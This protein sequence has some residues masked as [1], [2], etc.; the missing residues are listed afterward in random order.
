MLRKTLFW[1]IL[2]AFLVIVLGSL[3]ALGWFSSHELRS[4]FMDRMK[5][6]LEK[7]AKLV[8]HSIKS[9]YPDPQPSEID[10]I[11]KRIGQLT[12]SR[13]TVIAPDGSVLGDSDENPEDMENHAD[14][15]EIRAAMQGHPAASERYSTTLQQNMI[16]F[17]VP[18]RSADSLLGV[19]RTSRSLKSFE[20]AL[21]ATR[22]KIFLASCVVGLFAVL[23][24][25][26][27]SQRV[28]RPLS[29]IRQGA[30]RFAN[31]NLKTRLP[32]FDVAEFQLLANTMNHMAAELD[33][34]IGTVIQQR[35]E[36]E[37]ILSSMTEGVLAVDTEAKIIRLNRAAAEML[38]LDREQAQGKTVQATIRNAGLQKA[39][40]QTLS[41]EQRVR[42][43][44]VAY[45][46]EERYF[47]V[48]GALV[49][50][51]ADRVMGAVLVLNDITQMRKLENIRKDF[52]A[53][54]SH[55]LRTPITSI[56][57]FVETLLD[58]ALESKP[59]AERFLGIILKQT[60]RLNAILEDLLLLSR[61]ER[62]DEEPGLE[63]DRHRLK[64]VLLTA[65][66]VCEHK[67]KDKSI[68]ITLNCPADIYACLNPLLMEQAAVNIIDN[69][70]NYSPEGSAIEV[71]AGSEN[72]EL[73][74]SVTDQGCGIPPE[75]LPRIFERFYR[76]DKARSRQ[77][78]GTGLG[79]AILK[80]VAQAHGGRVSVDS[81]VGRGSTFR[82]HLP[83]TAES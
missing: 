33:D 5:T 1:K 53:N 32:Y 70:I 66:Q 3:L 24:S 54:V 4:F 16:Y 50:D 75:H 11:C 59:D 30:Q 21:S 78:G 29:E 23:L 38:G 39:L 74:I 71:R 58:G 77:L 80:H 2:P 48:N 25:F 45:D 41:E 9:S 31:G 46:D 63:F 7:R 81:Q 44:V 43:K 37:A 61:V 65:I 76:V 13:V 26:L 79:L 36:A 27:A 83:N 47:Q 82:I 6:T 52:V 49:K 28:T 64:D 34:R 18:I 73:I 55:E 22:Y 15:P 8:R 72:G 60:N 19:V 12:D 42:A 51:A 14:R 56:Q 20:Q 62:E 69:A 40:R 57:G 10:S 17:A 35:N 67:A 68:D